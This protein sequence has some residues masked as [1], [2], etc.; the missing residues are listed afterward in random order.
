MAYGLLFCLVHS[1]AGLGWGRGG[2][3]LTL[4]A[5]LDA[6]GR[7]T[8]V[9]PRLALL[10]KAAGGAP[11]GEIAIPQIASLTHIARRLA[12]PLSRTVIVADGPFMREVQVEL[13]PDADGMDVRVT[14]WES[15][16]PTP[17]IALMPDR[18][19]DFARLESDG[20]WRT[21]GS[22]RIVRM[23]A[24]IERDI[25]FLPATARGL[26]LTRIF[27]PVPDA[28]GDMPML[29]ALANGTAFE[30][31][32][33]ELIAGGGTPILLSATP[34]YDV[35]GSFL[36][37]EGRFTFIAR[38][39]DARPD[40]K[41][42]PLAGD[43]LADRLDQALRKP[44]GE[45]IAQ[46][47]ATALQQDGPLQQDYVRY[48]GDI[49]SAARHLLGLV[50]DLANLNA[51][52]RPDFRIETE[53]VDLVD[54]IHRAAGLL[55]L[56]IAEKSLLLDL[57]A[58]GASLY[59]LGDF[60]RVLQILVN[61]LANAI[62]YSPDKGRISVRLATQADQVSL[63]LEDEGKGIS[64]VDQERIF[65]KFQR[66]DLT[67]TGGSGLGLYISRRLAQAMGGS[68]SVDSEPGQGSCFTLVLKAAPLIA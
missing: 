12:L 50:D 43:S 59:A 15:A 29:A 13:K 35:S 55:S 45:I 63:S 60:G 37:L 4:S 17:D 49:G 54:I 14:G 21:D 5:R 27:R 18:D 41:P 40:P 61:L 32:P 20:A 23:A 3:V 9:D 28:T 46:A 8:A 57:P 1:L 36:G 56:R 11:D 48:A 38:E 24:G 64:A 42:A 66:L 67:E 25:G 51:V 31:Q 62:R 39:A 44:I 2:C 10:Q 30:D 7:L 26:P 34:N 22:L 19:F 58:R 52:E 68:L 33:A 47:D 6:Q 53:R 16:A 65:E